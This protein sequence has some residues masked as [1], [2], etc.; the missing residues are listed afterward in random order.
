MGHACIAVSPGVYHILSVCSADDEHMQTHFACK[1]QCKPPAC[2]G[3]CLRKTACLIGD[4]LAPQG[5]G[6]QA[7]RS[8]VRESTITMY[9]PGVAMV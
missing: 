6:D 1:V 2:R 5:A 3:T 4:W 8:C 7:G 9:L